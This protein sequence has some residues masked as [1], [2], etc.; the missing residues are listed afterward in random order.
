MPKSSRKND[1]EVINVELAKPMGIVFSERPSSLGLKISSLPPTGH[2][3]RTSL[4]QPYDILHKVNGVVMDKMKFED[5]MKVLADEG[6]ERVGG[7]FWRRRRGGSVGGRVRGV[8]LLAPANA[9][10][11]PKNP[12]KTIP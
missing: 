10:V 2:A 8:R 5:A 9:A 6:G 7:V 1:Y 12:P 3:Y 4:L 11:N